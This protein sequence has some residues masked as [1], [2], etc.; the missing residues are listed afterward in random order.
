MMWQ[1]CIRYPNGQEKPLQN[2]RNRELALKS[3]DAIYSQGYPMHVA[4]VVRPI[5]LAE[6]P[7]T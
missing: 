7:C 4:Y 1:L 3:V 2:Y 6:R 5:A